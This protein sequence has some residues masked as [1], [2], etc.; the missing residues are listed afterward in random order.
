[1]EKPAVSI[2]KVS[3]IKNNTG[4]FF[5][6]QHNSTIQTNQLHVSGTVSS[7]HQADP[8]NKKKGTAVILVGDVGPHNVLHNI[9]IYMCM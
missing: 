7:H 2:V 4:F 6:S 8:N 9:R 1:M 5:Q 3:L